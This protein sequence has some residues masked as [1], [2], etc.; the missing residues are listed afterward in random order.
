[1]KGKK[2]VEKVRQRQ[3]TRPSLPFSQ[4]LPQHEKGK[5]PR[6]PPRHLPIFFFFFLNCLLDFFL[7][8]FLHVWGEYKESITVNPDRKNFPFPFFFAVF[9][10]Y[11]TQTSFF[12]SAGNSQITTQLIM[13]KASPKAWKINRIPIRF[14]RHPQHRSTASHEET[15]LLKGSRLRADGDS[16]R[17]TKSRSFSLS[18]CAPGLGLLK[19][20]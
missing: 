14:S 10:I 5:E 16:P 7:I 11:K 3:G 12:P 17:E 9:F 6:G 4:T 8:L 20:N 18:A 15:K 13:L 2:K 1:M 19:E